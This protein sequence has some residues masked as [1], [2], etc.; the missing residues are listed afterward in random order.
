HCLYQAGYLCVPCL[1]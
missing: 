1:S